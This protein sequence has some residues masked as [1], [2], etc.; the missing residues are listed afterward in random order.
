MFSVNEKWLSLN[1]IDNGFV[2]G[3]TIIY[4]ISPIS[5]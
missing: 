1:I 5:I 3:K 4:V 2:S